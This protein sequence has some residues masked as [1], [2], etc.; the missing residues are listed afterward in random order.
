MEEETKTTQTGENQSEAPEEKTVPKSLFDSKI[1]ELN[2]Q[3]KE[4]EA[5][6]KAKMTEDELKT[7]EANEKNAELQSLKNEVAALK[8]ESAFTEAGIKPEIAKTLSA[9]IVGADASAI[10]EAVKSAI[11]TAQK[12]AAAKATQELLEKGSPKVQTATSGGEKPDLNLEI[13]KRAVK[14]PESKP[15]SESKW[16]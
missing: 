14:K 12:E 11:S 8:T 9:A 10:V 5:Q 15:L 13:I 2:K 3:K 16:F 7:A 6:L 4:L 1:S